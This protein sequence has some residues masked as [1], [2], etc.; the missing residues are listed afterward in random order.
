MPLGKDGTSGTVSGEKIRVKR[1]VGQLINLG[2][3]VRKQD[4]RLDAMCRLDRLRMAVTV[5][6][7]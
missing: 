2:M 7:T 3:E 1:V 6:P 4:T 5:R